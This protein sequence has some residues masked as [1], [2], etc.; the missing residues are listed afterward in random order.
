MTVAV[1]VSGEHAGAM[2]AEEL[3][4]ALMEARSPASDEFDAHVA[5]SILTISFAE[6]AA[7]GRSLTS[8]TGLPC[9][10]LAS[11]IQDVFP[12]AASLRL[13]SPGAGVERGADESCLL[14]LLERGATS[15]SEFEAFLAAMIARRAQRPNHLWQDLGL[16]NRRELSELM[17]ATSGRWR[18]AIRTT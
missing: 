10:R 1:N 8:A 11:L 13:V 3:Y 5:A 17:R 9:E 4:A 12:A 15:G 7:E 16:R 18:C 6:A 2:H 14:D